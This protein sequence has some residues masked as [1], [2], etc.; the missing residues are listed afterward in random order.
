M[1][2]IKSQNMSSG[3]KFNVSPLFCAFKHCIFR[4]NLNYIVKFSE[5]W[6]FSQIK[7]SHSAFSIK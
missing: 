2:L 6:F 1:L 7:R 4:E 5:K 3:L